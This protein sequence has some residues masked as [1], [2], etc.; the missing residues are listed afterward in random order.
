MCH[1]CGAPGGSLCTVHLLFAP[2]T[3]GGDSRVTADGDDGDGQGSRFW[4]IQ[5]GALLTE[6]A[7]RENFGL[8]EV[9]EAIFYRRLMPAAVTRPPSKSAISRALHT[10]PWNERCPWCPLWPCHILTVK[11][12]GYFIYGSAQGSAP[13]VGSHEKDEIWQTSGSNPGSNPFF[14][15]RGGVLRVSGWCG[16]PHR[17]GA[18]PKENFSHQKRTFTPHFAYKK[19]VIRS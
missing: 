4:R 8:L 16:A 12:K 14:S 19:W 10:L 3:W 11:E 6:A 5:G 17:R 15:L 18:A 2:V 13:Q 1:L 9:L 7:Q